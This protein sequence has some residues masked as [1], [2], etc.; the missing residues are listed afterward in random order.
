MIRVSGYFQQ[1]TLHI[2][3]DALFHLVHVLRI[4]LHESFEILAEEKVYACQVTSLKPLSFSVLNTVE[5]NTEL[6]HKITLLYVIPKGD[7][8][9]L[10]IQKAVELGIDQLI[11]IQSTHSVVIWTPA[12]WEQKKPRFLKQI[13]DATLQCKRT[14]KMKLTG[15]FTFKEAINLVFDYRFIASEHHLSTSS[16]HDQ[17]KNATPTASLAMLVG[18]EGGFTT[19]EVNQAIEHGFLPLSLGQRILRTETAAIASCVLLSSWSEQR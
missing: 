18:A 12:Q 4:K 1:K 16:L 19:E 15:V 9:D 10:V 14:S 7:K 3:E 6:P 17:L 2:D 8:L 11:L 5:V 13:H